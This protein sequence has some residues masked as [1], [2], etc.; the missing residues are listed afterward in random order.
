MQVYDCQDDMKEK[1]YRPA[2][3][4]RTVQAACVL[5]RDL[6]PLVHEL[7]SISSETVHKMLYKLYA[8]SYEVPEGFT[9]GQDVLLLSIIIGEDRHRKTKPFIEML[10]SLDVFEGTGAY[11]VVIDTRPDLPTLHAGAHLVDGLDTALTIAALVREQEPLEK[12]LSR[13]D[14]LEI[15]KMRVLNMNIVRKGN[16]L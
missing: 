13:E 6:R 1:V 15:E 16:L 2:K 8:H 7:G 11:Y 5:L 14:W 10:K 4:D 3:G 9:F 12:E